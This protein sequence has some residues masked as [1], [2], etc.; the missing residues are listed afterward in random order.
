MGG[1]I[2]ALVSKPVLS[3][4]WRRSMRNLQARFS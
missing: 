4:V 3:W 1:P 2:G